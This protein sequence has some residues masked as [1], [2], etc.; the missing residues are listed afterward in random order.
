MSQRVE[1]V[2]MMPNP[3][4]VNQLKTEL[5]CSMLEARKLAIR[6][7]VMEELSKPDADLR[8]CIATLMLHTLGDSR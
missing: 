8:A 3:M 7:Q 1:V 2:P 5:K 6:K 4:V